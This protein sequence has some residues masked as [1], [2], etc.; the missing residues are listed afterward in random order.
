M[1]V[2]QAFMK[3]DSDKKGFLILRDFHLNFSNFFDLSLRNTEVRNLFQEMDTDANGILLF[4]ELDN[5]Y[6]KDYV[7]EIKNLER[8]KEQKNT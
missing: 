1:P 5:W 3:L 8:E 4:E 6:K 7:Q 2:Q